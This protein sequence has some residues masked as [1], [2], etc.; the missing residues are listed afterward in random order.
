M[1]AILPLV[2]RLLV[3]GRNLQQHG[4]HAKAARQFAALTKLHSIPSDITEEAHLHLA[5]IH[6]EHGR[7][8][9]ARRHLAAALARQPHCAQ[10]HYL[11][12]LAIEEDE[13]CDQSRAEGYY[14]RCLAIDPD[15]AECLCDY[16]Q[17]SLNRGLARKALTA[18]RHVAALA[19]DDP[20]LLGRVAQGLR[21]A[22]KSDEAKQLLRAALFRNPHDRRFRE[23]WTA[24]QFDLLHAAQRPTRAQASAET[25][26]VP[27]ILRFP[28]RRR[29][30]QDVAGKTIRTDDASEFRGPT[31]LPMHVA[32]K[33][34]A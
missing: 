10:Y 7:P 16:A 2:D 24:H 28:R 23:L 13:D 27:V 31:I 17:Y 5:E 32:R 4:Q 34:D 33:K 25:Q 30:V 29:K 3:H 9:E 20:D 21:R 26:G 6:L 11:M 8:R 15:N 1:S 14:R 12:A 19:N 22:N 18:L